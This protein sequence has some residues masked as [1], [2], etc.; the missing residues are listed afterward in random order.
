MPS[1]ETPNMPPSGPPNQPPDAP[2]NPPS[3]P[4]LTARR[5]LVSPYEIMGEVAGS[6]RLSAAGWIIGAIAAPLLML[7]GISAR[8]MGGGLTEWSWPAIILIPP[9]IVIVTYIGAA[10]TVGLVC[11]LVGGRGE[12]RRHLAAWA[13]TYPPTIYA[14]AVIILFHFIASFV[15]VPPDARGPWFKLLLF[16][17]LAFAFLWKVLLYLI[18]L[19]V[20]GGLGFIQMLV[21]SAILMVV[22]FLYE[23]L[24]L[25]L[26]LGQVPFI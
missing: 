7:F 1:N 5:I 16:G 14:F 20:V 15:G 2:S 21:A 17:L 13:L 19:R 9:T 26:G 3:M 6:G 18:H 10:L 4:P 24:I 12:P 8:G 22:V 25:E 11:K 23:I